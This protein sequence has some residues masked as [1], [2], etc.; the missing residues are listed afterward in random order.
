MIDTKTDCVCLDD[1]W[2][3]VLDAYGIQDLDRESTC[4]KSPEKEDNAVLR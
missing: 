4:D 1:D 2:G 3:S